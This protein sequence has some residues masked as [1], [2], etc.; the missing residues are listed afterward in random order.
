MTTKYDIYSYWKNKAITKNFE[1]K[2]WNDCIA[3]DEAINVTGF[4]DEIYCWACEMPPYNTA[5]TDNIKTL[6]NQDH[7]LTKA[8]ILAKSIGG[9]DS[10]SNLFLLCPNCHEESPDTTNPINF[11]AWIYYKRKYDNYVQVNSREFE[12]AAEIRGISKED[13]LAR[14]QHSAK[15]RYKRYEKK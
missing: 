3:E 11:F 13:L 8:H 1:V 9:D 4:P 5:D 2:R 15:L 6:W 10:P 14:F 12:K 7:L